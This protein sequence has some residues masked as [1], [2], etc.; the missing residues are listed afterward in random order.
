MSDDDD[1][2][3]WGEQ[4]AFSQAYDLIARLSAEH[5][6]AEVGK[7]VFVAALSCLRKAL[8][9]KEVAKLLYEAADDYAVRDHER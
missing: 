7:G 1:G 9:N 5:P 8:P 6:A 4:A 2:P 3:S